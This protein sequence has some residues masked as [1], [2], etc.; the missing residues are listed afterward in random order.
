MRPNKENI[1]RW[2]EAL[3]SGN[4]K[5][6]KG[7]LQVVDEFSVS[8]CCL[9]VAC[10]ISGLGKWEHELDSHSYLGEEAVLPSHVR[11]WLGLDEDNPAVKTLDDDWYGLAYLNDRG[12]YTFND[13]A[14][15]IERTWLGGDEQ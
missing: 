11:R 13:I 12:G 8:Y 10:D 5:Q 6:G 2:V 15:A 14:D 9:G 7:Y 4:Y 3:R 1:R